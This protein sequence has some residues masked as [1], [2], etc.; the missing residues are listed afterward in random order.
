MNACMYV[1]MNACMYECM[2]IWMYV[3]KSLFFKQERPEKIC[4]IKKVKSYEKKT[5]IKPGTKWYRTNL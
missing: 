2:T 4:N 3:C 5:R 1:C